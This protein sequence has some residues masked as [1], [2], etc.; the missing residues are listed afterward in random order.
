MTRLVSIVTSSPLALE[1]LVDMMTSVSPFHD[2]RD[3][4]GISPGD[5][6]RVSPS[7]L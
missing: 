5:K 1:A 3:V 2:A 4:T 7:K 6:F